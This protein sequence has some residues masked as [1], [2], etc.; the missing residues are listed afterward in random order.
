MFTNEEARAKALELA[1]KR[2]NGVPHQNAGHE[3]LLECAEKYVN[4]IVGEE[5][6]NSEAESEEIIPDWL[7]EKASLE[8]E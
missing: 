5:P 3:L 2:F 7:S 8:S 1:I 4:F 6:G